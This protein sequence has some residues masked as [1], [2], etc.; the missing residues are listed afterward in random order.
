VKRRA[1]LRIKSTFR[2]VM[3]NEEQKTSLNFGFYF[4]YFS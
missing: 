4:I 3:W 1:K 2:K